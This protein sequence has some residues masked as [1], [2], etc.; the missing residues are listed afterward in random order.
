M[1]HPPLLDHGEELRVGVIVYDHDG[2]V[3]QVKELDD[4]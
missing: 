2:N 1:G 3:R 4:A